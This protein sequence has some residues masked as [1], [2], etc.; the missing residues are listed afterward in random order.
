M[1]LDKGCD[2]VSGLSE[3]TRME[4]MG[5]VDLNDGKLQT[6]YAAYMKRHDFLETLKVEFEDICRSGLKNNLKTTQEELVTDLTFLHQGD[7]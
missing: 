6:Q 2:L 7:K 1:V 3:L 4:W 5:D